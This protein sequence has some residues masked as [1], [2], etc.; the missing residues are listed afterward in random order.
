MGDSITAGYYST[1]PHAQGAEYDKSWA[2]YVADKKGYNL[3]NIAIGGSGY[4]DSEHATD[5][6]NAKTK[7]NATNFANVDMVTLAYGCNDWKYGLPIGN[8]NDSKDA[9]NTMASNMKYVIEKILSDNPYCK[10][11]VMTPINCMGYDFDYGDFSTNYG[12]GFTNQSNGKTLEDVFSVQKS[13]CEYYGI[14]YIDNTH[15]S[16]VNRKNIRNML[17]DGVHPNVECYKVMANEISEKITF[18]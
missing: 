15:S 16:I 9:G 2:R 5:H 11:F 7:A 14:Q 13:I 3:T 12:L 6:T 17:L 18:M 8:V 4:L 10:I 1:G